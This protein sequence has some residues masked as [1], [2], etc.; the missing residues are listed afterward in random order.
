MA[1]H[2]GAQPFAL[3][4]NNLVDPPRARLLDHCVRELSATSGEEVA[5]LFDAL[6]TERAAGH[7]IALA[8]SYELGGVFEP[9]LASR[10]APA[11]RLRAWV[12][13]RCRDL[14]GDALEI[15]HDARFEELSPQ[16]REAGLLH[17]QP[18]WSEATHRE[19]TQRVLE[20]IRAGD[21]YQVNLT[22]PLRGELYGHPLALFERLRETQPVAYGALVHDGENWI[23]S[24]SPELFVERRGD[25]LHCRPMKGTAPREGDAARDAASAAGLLASDKERAE[26]LMI[27][28]LIRNDLG[29]LAPPGGVSVDRLFEVEHYRTV[30]QLTSS[31][32][33]APVE[34]PLA[35]VFAAL[36][37]C[38]S[39]TG[40]PKVRAMQIIDALEDG[41]RGLYCGALGWMAPTGDFRFSVPIR[42]L[43]IDA[44]GQC[45]LDVGS[46]IVADSQPA[47]EYDEC[48][49]KARFARN[50]KQMPELIETMLWDGGRFPLL[51]R[52]FERL[53]R[54]A[55]Q[56]GFALDAATIRA[57]L[58][59]LDIMLGSHAARVRLQ[60]ARD[61]R[62]TLDVGELDTL[63]ESRLVALADWAL[64]A[65]DPR[66][67]HKTT[68]RAFYNTA[69]R[70][71][72]VRGLYDI[73]FCNQRGE[74][75]EGAR[76]N[77]FLEIDG[78]LLTP[79]AHCGLLPGVM[80]AD[81]LA[82][83]EAREAVLYPADFARARRILLGN[84]LRGLVEVAFAAPAPRAD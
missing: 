75:A 52:H 5:A 76:S 22:F 54:S 11:T 12:F 14:E 7:W 4:E 58:A 53:A 42:T 26:N 59:Q 13:A 60:L 35:E 15:W 44:Y 49:T 6:E 16:Q 8:A 67:A 41:P 63:P 81:L 10:H 34:A 31:V 48:L 66:L 46:A 65:A 20:L 40:A 23:L 30:H 3:F 1:R 9:S 45:R 37:P 74:L 64:D 27:V 69:L 55:Q 39:V 17:L 71:A 43:R 82:R 78:E 84:A 80:R 83:G 61:G 72:Q 19:A 51:E 2:P 28:D 36:F 50:A 73:V 18:V 38:G 70:E 62:F 56:L 25:T 24:R 47:A 77:L 79:A 32:R 33:A 29:R 21:C 57:R 68:A